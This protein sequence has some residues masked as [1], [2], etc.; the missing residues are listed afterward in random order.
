MKG[1]DLSKKMISMAKFYEWFCDQKHK[2]IK[3]SGLIKGLENQDSFT[4]VQKSLTRAGPKVVCYMVGM[5]E[6]K[7]EEALKLWSD[8]VGIIALD[9]TPSLASPD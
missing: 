6:G 4:K 9:P 8:F 7:K 5:N 3:P 1:I 2:K